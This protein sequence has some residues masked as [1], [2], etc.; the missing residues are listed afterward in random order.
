MLRADIAS[1]QFWLHCLKCSRYLSIGSLPSGLTLHHS[2]LDCLLALHFVIAVSISLMGP[3]HVEL[4]M[5]AFHI[6]AILNVIYMPCLCR[7]AISG[8]SPPQLVLAPR[9]KIDHDNNTFELRG[10]QLVDAQ[11]QIAQ[12]RL[13]DPSL[14]TNGW[15][16]QAAIKTFTGY[17]GWATFVTFCNW[18]AVNKLCLNSRLSVHLV[19]DKL[20]NS[21]FSSSTDCRVISKSSW[22]SFRLSIRLRVSVCDI[23]MIIWN[24]WLVNWNC[25]RSFH[26]HW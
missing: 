24:I 1:L 26:S 20:I 9:W 23:E 18:K 6:L 12:D 7:C 21:N 22:Q 10:F 5:Q 17:N 11:L 8:E 16:V 4:H 14:E 2:Y 3:H 15:E 13:L 25:A 19:Q